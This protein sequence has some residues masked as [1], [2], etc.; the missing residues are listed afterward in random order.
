MKNS[1]NMKKHRFLL[2]ALIVLI[3]GGASPAWGQTA[4]TES[5]EDWGT[6]EVADGWLLINGAT[7][8]NSYSFDYVVGSDDFTPSS[9]NNCLGNSGHSAAQ[10][11]TS[12]PMIVTPAMTGTLT[13]KFRKYNSSSSTKG[14]INVFEYDEVS[15]TATGSSIW[16]CRPNGVNEATSKYQTASISVGD[17]PKRY[18]IYLAKVSVDEFTYTPYVDASSIAKPTD[19]ANTATTYNSAT[20]SWTAGGEETAWQLVYG[21]PGFDKDAATPV[22]V[23]TN[24][25]TLT[26]LSESTA[27]EAYI[28]AKKGDDVSSWTSKVSFTTPAQYPAPTAFALTGFTATSASFAWTAGGTETAWEMAYDTDENF[29][30]SSAGTKVT[31]NANPFTIEGLTAETTYYAYLRANYGTGYSAWTDKVTFKPSNEMDFTVNDGTTTN[32]YVPVYGNWADNV[33]YNKSQFIIESTSIPSL[34]NRQITKLTFY[35]NQ[36]SAVTWAGN[37]FDIYMKATDASSVSTTF[38]R[39]GTKVYTGSLSVAANGLMEVTLDDGFDYD[40]Q[41]LLIGFDM[42][43]KGEYKSVSFYGLTGNSGSSMYTN[44][45]SGV[46]QTFCP[47]V[48]FTSVPQSATPVAKMVVTADDP[49]AFG[50]VTPETA[51]A[52]KQKS[53]TIANTGKADLTNLSIVSDNPAF[54]IG[55][56]ATTIAQGADAITVT[57]TMDTEGMTAGV[58]NVTITISADDQTDATVNVSATYANAPATMDVTLAGT[59]VADEAIDFGSVNKE[60]SKTFVVTNNG[61]LTLNAT[62]ESNNTTD[63]SVAPASLVVAGGATAEFTVTFKKTEEYD[64]EKTANITLS[65]GE[66]SKVVAVK[67]TRIEMW[68]EDF[69]GGVI[70][71]GWDNNGF[72][73]KQNSIGS[74]PVYNLESFYAVGNGGSSNKTLVTPLLKANAGDKLTFDGFFYYGDET[75]VVDYSTDRTTWNNLYTYDKSSYSNGSTQ[76]IEIESA[77]SGEFYLRFTV[78]Y[79]NGIDNLNGF[80]L[81]KAKEHEAEITSVSIPAAGNQYVEYTATAT[82]KELAGKDEELTAKFFIGGTQY[83]GNVVK[84]VSANGT[85]TFTVTFT[86]DAAVSGDAYFTVSND[87]VS[88]ESDKT[89][90][91]IAEALVLDE[92]V[93]ATLTDGNAPIVVVK[94]TAKTGWNTITMPFNLSNDDLTAIFG[95][96]WK[97]YE[98][99][100]FDGTSSLEFKESTQFYAGYAYI[101]NSVEP[102][103]NT[104]YKQNVTIVAN[105]KN[106]SYNGATFYG[107]YAPMAAGTMTGKYGVTTE[108]RIAKGSASATMKG[109]RGYLELPDNVSNVR[110]TLPG[111][112]VL[113]GINTMDNGQLSMDNEAYDLQGRRVQNAKKGFFIINGKK[114]VK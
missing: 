104:L 7:Y 34:V 19:F 14:Y 73:V 15:G 12:S 79:F 31:V 83:G 57:V 82:V 93:A 43:T 13:F 68:S 22:E 81:A 20:F 62:L 96:G 86:P 70:P 78:N 44:N 23:T 88:L 107:T 56:Y 89:A 24:P 71:E 18:A 94:Y 110:I 85:E 65:A 108:G 90:V 45:G 92:T 95:T 99:K 105:P 114:V 111:G 77:I 64:V 48:T 63:F 66:L 53:F 37:V 47:K 27:Y 51:A 72:V 58:K 25:F 97:A 39:T 103:N 102:A 106:D 112:E 26:G 80:K 84:T 5:F 2:L 69:E 29:D 9:G 3:M 109:F 60:V 55:S 1:Y 41:N 42:T 21:A 33:N 50:K 61:D 40:G 4:S 113:T 49:I 10:G 32:F 91:T 76:N 17:S 75:L 36:S 28:R 11:T 30:P 38:D 46:M 54:V 52:D 101:V 100:G 98:L 6:T 74:Y 8:G 87:D 16:T 67:G 35:T 59:A